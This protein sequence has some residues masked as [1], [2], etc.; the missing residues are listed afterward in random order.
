M[1]AFSRRRYPSR[2]ATGTFFHFDVVGYTDKLMRD[3]G[4]VS[5][6]QGGWWADL[7]APCLASDFKDAKDEYMAKIGP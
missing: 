3:I 4:L 1:A 6:R 2:G 7:T 5:H